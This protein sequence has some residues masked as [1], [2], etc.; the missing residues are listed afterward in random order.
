MDNLPGARENAGDQVANDW[1]KMWRVTLNWK[2][3]CVLVI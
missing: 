3:L 2:L 1:L